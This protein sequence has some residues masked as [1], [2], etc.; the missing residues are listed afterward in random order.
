MDIN[1]LEVLKNASEK[2]A[3]D[4]FIVAGLPLSMKVK[5]EI[6]SVTE[7]KLTPNDTA[8]LIREIYE[9]GKNPNFEKF[10]TVGDSDFSFSTSVGRFR[11]NTYR[12]RGSLAAVLRI[13][14]FTLPDPSSLG[15][16]PAVMELYNKQKGI[17]LITGPTGSGK[18]TTLACVIDSINKNR[19]GHIITL[20]DPLEFIHSHKQSIVSQREI[21]T[22]S[23]T[24]LQAIKSALRQSPDVILV[25][26]MRDIETIGIALTAAETGHLLLSTLHTMGAAQTIDRIIDIFPAN[27]QQQIRVQLSMTLQA[28]V[29]QQLIPT[30][31]KGL[32]AAFEVMMYNTAIANLIR[33]NK[34]HQ[35]NSVIHTSGDIGMQTMDSSL[36]ALVKKGAITKETAMIYSANPD[37]IARML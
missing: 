1:L 12:Q 4:I 7:D 24:Y 28:V 35:I 11:V 10:A 2:K 32:V 8:A 13:V 21:P 37:I 19:K 3:S 26:E 22:D 6:I 30:V 36:V 5:G 17:I 23:L 33:E 20:E 14:S 25:G 15:I 27:Q 16:P 18:S 29:S 9:I 31:D 34:L